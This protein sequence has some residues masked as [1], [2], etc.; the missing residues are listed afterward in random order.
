MWKKLD[1]AQREV[2][3]VERTIMKKLTAA[4][5]A[6]VAAV[7]LTAPALRADVVPISWSGIYCGPAPDPT[8]ANPD[9]EDPPPMT[10]TGSA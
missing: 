10:T 2:P 5:T 1:R 3:P 9:P 6:T 8:D 4:A 7:T